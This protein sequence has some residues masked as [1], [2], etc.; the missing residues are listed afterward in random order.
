MHSSK[1]QKTAN[2][3]GENPISDLPPSP[4]SSKGARSKGSKIHFIATS[5]LVF[6]F[7]ILSGSEP[8]YSQGNLL[9]N[10]VQTMP[11][12]TAVSSPSPIEARAKVKDIALIVDG[13]AIAARP[14]IEDQY[15]EVALNVSDTISTYEVQTG[16]TISGIAQK[17]DITTNTIIWANDLDS[18]KPLKVGQTLIILPV[19]GVKY[20]VKKGDILSKVAEKYKGNVDEIISYNNLEDATDITAGEQIIIPNG[21]I[22]K[23]VGGSNSSNVGSVATTPEVGGFKGSGIKKGWLM[24]PSNGVK[25]QNLHG[26]NGVDIA[27]AKGSPIYAAAGGKAIIVKSN[28]AWNGGYGNYIVISHPNGVQTLYGHLNGVNISQGATVKQGQVIG[29][30]GTTGDSSGVHLHFEVRGATNP[31]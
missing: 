25:S 30:M 6:S 19:P 20:T 22:T 23:L 18:K 15:E 10:S 28:G 26:H 14:A 17:F 29:Y 7:F 12:L 3:K 11:I 8:L 31:F 21:E 16:D 2:N 24:R 4:T 13:M 1:Q 5:A 9:K 27:G